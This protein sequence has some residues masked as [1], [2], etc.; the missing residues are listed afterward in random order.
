MLYIIFA[1]LIFFGLF[2]FSRSDEN[3]FIFSQYIS[4]VKRVGSLKLFVAL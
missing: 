2:T 1:L 3:G 4:F